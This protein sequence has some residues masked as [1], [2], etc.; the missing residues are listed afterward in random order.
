MPDRIPRI[1]PWAGAILWIG[2]LLAPPIGE[3]ALQPIYTLLAFAV[4]VLVSLTL[5]LLESPT[6]SS[7]RFGSMRATRIWQPIAALLAVASLI[8]P[9]GGP[10]VTL[11][12][13]WFAF[14]GS[15]SLTGLLR[16]RNPGGWTLDA[17]VKDVGMLYLAVGGAWLVIDRLG[18][19]PLGFSDA[20]V[21]LTA[22]HFHY[23]GFIA[24]VLTGV[25]ADSLP[26]HS[27]AARSL[28]RAG[29]LG[30]IIGPPIIA[31]GITVSGVVE[32]V[33]VIAQTTGLSL[34][35]LAM[36]LGLV[37]TSRPPL[38]RGLLA[39][40]SLSVFG[41]MLL[42]V[43]YA[44]GLRTNFWTLTIPQMVTVHGWGNALG[45]ALPGVLA[46][47]RIHSPSRADRAVGRS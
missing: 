25:F 26:A 7:N 11:A 37:R 45:F 6:G 31:L 32:L 28:C 34:V 4:L 24:P 29:A 38:T 42:A 8:L 44:V 21:A 2:L 27:G 30:V 16:L 40:A 3:G 47:R 14:T 36:W 33:G 5:P 43:G 35:A 18:A 9:P 1:F 17:V 13:G 15:V 46:A 22:I 10:A 41:G 20:I 19:N 39:L 23:A 12:L